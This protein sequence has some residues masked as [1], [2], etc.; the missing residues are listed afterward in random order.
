MNHVG[1]FDGKKLVS[2]DR[3]DLDLSAIKSSDDTEEKETGPALE[4]EVVKSLTGWI[5][6]ALGDHVKEVIVSKRLVESPAIIVN[7]DGYMTSTMERVMQAARLE[8]G[9]A[10]QQ[11]GPKNLEINANHPLIKQLSL[12]RGTDEGF[13]QNVIEQIFDNALIQA[14]LMI[15]PRKMVERSYKILERATK[16]ND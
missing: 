11:A 15:D 14:G 2:A 6:E 1:E 13:A 3:A 7:P 10:F 8:K 12:L 5:K 9:E 16:G 4:P